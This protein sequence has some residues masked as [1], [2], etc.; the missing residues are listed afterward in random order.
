M[1]F[2][3]LNNGLMK[4]KA[5]RR[6]DNDQTTKHNEWS[7]LGNTKVTHWLSVARHNA[8]SIEL[9]YAGFSQIGSQMLFEV[10]LRNKDSFES[11]T[12]LKDP[13]ITRE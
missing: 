7:T 1:Q 11:N 13:C 6:T 8:Q 9:S 5:L 3:P 10:F 12:S 2:E 4:S